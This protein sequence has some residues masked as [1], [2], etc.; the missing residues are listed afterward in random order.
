V[1]VLAAVQQYG[2]ALKYASEELYAERKVVLAAVQEYG[3]AL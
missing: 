2:D 1:I 3:G